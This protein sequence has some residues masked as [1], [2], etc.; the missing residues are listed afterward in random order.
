[1]LEI[2]TSFLFLFFLGCLGWAI[3]AFLRSPMPAL[4]GSMTLI[5]ALKIAGYSLPVSPSFLPPFV[6]VVLGLY[7]G[8]KLTKDTVRELKT[9]VLPALIIVIWALS[10][11]FAIGYFLSQ[12]TY[13]DPVTAILSSSIGGLP[14]MTIIALAIGADIV[15]IIIM[16]SIRMIATAVAFPFIV[17]LWVKKEKNDSALTSKELAREEVAE[18]NSRRNAFSFSLKNCWLFLKEKTRV[19]NINNLGSFFSSAG[20]GIFSLAIATAGGVLF[21]KL[22]VPA[23]GMVGAMFFTAIVSLLGVPVVTPSPTAFSFMLV[24]V[25]MMVS[26]NLSPATL[27]TFLSGDILAP[28]IISNALIFMSSL[29]VAFFIHKV[30]GWDF[31]T[32]FLAAAP[33]GFTVMT[34]LAIKYRKNP[35]RVSML[36]LCRLLAIKSVVP[37]VFM[38]Y[39]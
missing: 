13:L 36:H 1:M 5:G 4:L 6:Q 25:G 15:V 19:S 28:V 8:S 35:F 18:I 31:P 12:V 17:N 23:G 24:G 33:G 21:L 29:L 16:Q 27:A 9:I 32:S 30:V 2:I 26:D 14:E 37:F 10:V 34:A 7:V 39:I 38:L 22:G 11:V 20:R 3:F